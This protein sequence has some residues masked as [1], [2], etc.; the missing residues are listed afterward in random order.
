LKSEKGK[1]KSEKR[2]LFV[3]RFSLFR[4]DYFDAEVMQILLTF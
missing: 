2:K 1:A 4:E 3:F